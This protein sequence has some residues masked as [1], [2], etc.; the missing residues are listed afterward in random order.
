MEIKKETSRKIIKLEGYRGV[1]D[2]CQIDL[3]YLGELFFIE[4]VNDD[5][6]VLL[7]PIDTLFCPNCSKTIGTVTLLKNLEISEE[8]ESIGKGKGYAKKY[9]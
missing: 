7:V 1:C 8:L 4:I 5:D 2:A 6:K 9:Q 3:E